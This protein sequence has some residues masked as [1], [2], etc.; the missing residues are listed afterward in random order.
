MQS[1]LLF[2][3]FD[4]TQIHSYTLLS[5]SHSSAM[6]DFEFETHDTE[7]HVSAVIL[8]LDGTLLNTEQATKDV[9]KQFLAKYGKVLDRE[10]ENKRLGMTHK[11]S[12]IAII[13]DYDL[14]IPPHRY[15]QE[16]MPLYQ[17]KWVEAKALPGANRLIMHLHKHQ[18]P[19]ALASNSI[20]QN[21][22]TKISHQQGWKEC[23]SVILGSDQVKLGKPAPDLF[24]EAA[25]KMGVDAVRCLVIEDSL[26]GVKAAKAA[27]MKVVAIPSLQS[28]AEQ[29]H[30]ADSVL[31]SLLEFQPEMWGLP[32]FE[33]WVDNT[34]PVEPFHLKGLYSH[35]L[36]CEFADSGPSALPDQVSGVYFGWG[37]VDTDEIFKV[38]TGIGWDHGCCTAKRKIRLCPVD[39]SKEDISNQHMQVLLVGYIR[40]MT[41]KGNTS[42]EIEIVEEDKLIASDSLDLPVYAHHTCASFFS[43][44]SFEDDCCLG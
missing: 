35:G 11:E 5:S 20:R 10:K 33:D 23:F 15:T 18:V 19:F 29:Y 16:I 36:L 2:C 17:E 31:H 34:L 21:I 40:G 13:K 7:T 39:G 14:P 22:D 8:D 9:L 30:I 28:E 43:E 37:I 44:A 6:N 32:P 25:N 38:V 27:G 12:A 42:A 4:P 26:I 3:F 24:L 41:G 1:S